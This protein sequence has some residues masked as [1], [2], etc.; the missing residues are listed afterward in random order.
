MKVGIV[1]TATAFTGV[2]I[3][4]A[5][6]APAED[7]ALNGTYTAVWTSPSGSVSYQ[8]DIDTACDADGCVAHVRN[9]D[10]GWTADLLYSGGQ[11]VAK[12]HMP[13]AISCADGRTVAGTQTVTLEHASLTGSAI[14]VAD[15]A[16]CGDGAVPPS[17]ISLTK[18]G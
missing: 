5:T 12:H 14:A 8:W 17:S 1:I 9:P 2:A 3:A 6:P 18:V 11:W 10:D 15:G 4:L 13:D 7:P 16:G